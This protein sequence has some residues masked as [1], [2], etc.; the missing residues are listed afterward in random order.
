RLLSGGAALADVVG[1]FI[2]AQRRMLGDDLFS[3]ARL[4]LLADGE[5]ARAIGDYVAEMDG[6][7]RLPIGD[8]GNPSIDALFE[9][10]GIAEEDRRWREA[11]AIYR[12]VTAIAPRDAVARFNLAN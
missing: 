2:A 6:Q 4:T 8:G 5:L 7:L 9:R 1:A 10:A 12:R 3:E 11:E